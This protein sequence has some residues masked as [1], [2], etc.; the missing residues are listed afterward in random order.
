MKRTLLLLTLAMPL[1]LPAVDAQA[2]K[3]KLPPARAKAIKKSRQS[4]EACRKD[5]LA[6]LKAGSVTKKAFES[7]LSR[8]KE[9]YPGASLYTDCKKKAVKTAK[10]K[11][12]SPDKAV[13]QCKRYLTAASFDPA[14]PLPFFVEGGQVFF[15]GVGLNRPSPVSALT[16]PNFD[17]AKLTTIAKSPEQAQYFLFGN[18][19]SMFAGLD[20]K[21]GSALMKALRLTKPSK[22]GADVNGFG[23]VFGDPGKASG[24]AFFPTAACDFDSELGDI[25]AGLS[26]YYLIDAASSAVFPY[27]GIAYFKQGQTAVTTPKLVQRIV[28]LLGPNFKPQKKD[29]QVTFIAAGALS[30]KDE[31]KDPKNLCL[32]PRQHR[33]VGVVQSRPGGGP[34]YM[35]LA[36]VKNLCDFGDRLAKRLVQ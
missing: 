9:S 17:C 6:Q 7:T 18:H 4:F 22:K 16:P 21:K 3:G 33:F 28:K 14:E 29:A 13:E 31:E 26:A 8:C 23:R 25:F 36:N 24:M 19:P 34:E 20:D 11:N 12:L 32:Q 15:A 1:A 30:E 35:L 2:Q 5:A 27:F 10:D